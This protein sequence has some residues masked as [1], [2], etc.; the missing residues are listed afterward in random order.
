MKEK[1]GLGNLKN[2]NKGLTEKVEIYDTTLRDGTQ[3][4]G[5]SLSLDDKLQITEILDELGVDFIE[6]GFP[7]SNPRDRK[8][9]EQ[10]S[11]KKLNISKL[12]AFGST[13]RKNVKPKEDAGL[14]IL[15][16]VETDYAA[17]FGKSW[18][19]H[20]K[21]ILR[22]SLEENIDIIY[23]SI[24][25]LKNKGK[26]VFFDAEHFFDGFKNNPEYAVSSVKAAFS[27][28]AGR[29][30]LCDTNG[31]S[32]PNEISEIVEK[33]G[34][35]YGV[36]LSRLGIHAHNDTDCAV[37]NSLAAVF[38]G[39]RHIQ[40]TINGYGERTGNANLSSI[41]PDLELKTRFKTVGKSRLKGLLKASRLVDEISNNIPI[42]NMPFVGESAFA[43]KAGMHANAVMKN[44]SS[45][46]HI[47][48]EFVGNGRRF[49]ISDLSGKSNIEAKAK[50]LGFDLSRL[51]SVQETELLNKIKEMESSG[52][53]FESADGS[54]KILLNK[55]TSSGT[56]EDT[57]DKYFKLLAFR[58]NIEK[59]LE[60]KDIFSEAVVM[61]KVKDK[62]EHTVAIG[63]GPVNALDNALRKA[64][65]KFYPVL[66]EMRLS[67]FK[68]RVINGKTKS[69]TA[70]YVRVLIESSDKEE[71]W[72]TIGVS[73]NIIEASYMALA[74]GIR[75]KLSKEEKAAA[76]VKRKKAHKKQ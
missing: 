21:G 73:E 45:Y 69:G 53:N 2:K 58:V 18:D 72:T 34:V 49:L 13:S 28:G 75:Y 56:A 52:F 47:E 1:K 9:F 51:S 27:A 37:A 16:E 11:R 38:A 59:A 46:E 74:D 50:E 41:I 19:L 31:G 5:F 23:N 36:D 14:K 68:V 67:D 17:I 64:L 4:E 70:S 10:S 29:V 44:P 62:T 63:D 26:N 12:V 76:Q 66:D 8:F 61:I 35:V 25:F 55:Y 43:H 7:A 54:F 15:S 57:E 24:V 32:L 3:G 71:Q 20:V 60:N 33:L 48:P 65:V 30:V 22:A 42:K 39:I 40:G 6:G